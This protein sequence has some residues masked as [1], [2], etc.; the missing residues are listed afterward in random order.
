MN[1][2]NSTNKKIITIYKLFF[3]LCVNITEIPTSTM[4]A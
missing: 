4:N 2:N 3:L 1:N